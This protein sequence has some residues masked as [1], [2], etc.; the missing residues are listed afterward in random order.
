MVNA[1]IETQADATDLDDRLYDI[2]R[3]DF[4]RLKREFERSPRK[5]TTVQSLKDAIQKKLEMMLRQNPLRTDFQMHYEKL[6]AEYNGEKDAV[7]IERTFAALLVLAE[8]L[9][10][11][12]RRAMR[13]GLDEETLALFDL[14][15]KPDLEK[16]DIARLKAVAVGLYEVLKTHLTIV[17][18]FAKKQATRDAV[19]VAITNFLY[20]DRTGLPH[21]YEPDEVNLKAQAV[22]AHVRTHW[23]YDS[24][25]A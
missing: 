16:G 11:E 9:D 4:E 8:E 21:S 14:L 13:E 15:M 1:S 5:N 24:H 6:V 20:D 3:I 22:F 19:R 10:V 17:Q 2:S 23:G 18:D 25:A 12:Q 7:N